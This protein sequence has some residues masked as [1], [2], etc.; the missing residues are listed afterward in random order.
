[1][2]RTAFAMFG[3]D[4][5]RQTGRPPIKCDGRRRSRDISWSVDDAWGLLVWRAALDPSDL[6]GAFPRIGR[7]V[8]A[9]V[10]AESLLLREAD[11]R[12]RR[13]ETRAA[14]LCGREGSLSVPPTLM[15]AHESEVARGFDEQQDVVRGS[16]DPERTLLAMVAPGASDHGALA[17]CV[18]KDRDRRLFAVLVARPGVRF[19]EEHA[20]HFGL[21]REP[22]AIACAHHARYTDLERLHAVDQADKQAL[23]SKLGSE[24]PI[25]G[26]EGG[27]RQVMTQVEQVARTDAPVLVMG[28]TGSGKEVIARAIHFRS[29]RAKGPVVRVNCGAIPPELIDSELFGHEKGSFTG[30]IAARQGWFE[31]ADGGTLFLDEIGEL[32]LAAQVRLL[33]VL[34][35]GTL[36]R[37]GGSKTLKVDVR[38][39]AATHRPLQEMVAEGT[40]REDLWYRISVFVLYL[41]ALRER[42]ADIPQLADHFAR[43]SASRLGVPPLHVTA[44]DVETLKAYGWPGNIRELGAVIERAAILGNGRRL[45]VGAALGQ[46]RPSGTMSVPPPPPESSDGPFPTLDEAMSKHI[47]AALARAG[48]IIEGSKGAAALLGINPH[49]LR[50]RMRKMGI[51]WDRFRKGARSAWARA[52][53]GV[54]P[55][56]VASPSAAWFRTASSRATKARSA[57]GPRTRSSHHSFESSAPAAS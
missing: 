53:L 51:D 46:S 23:M 7:L 12:V 11:L 57:S 9:R 14:S 40:F 49:T 28:E 31:R 45:D 15:T 2:S 32:S 17:A 41:P 18:A 30:A 26:A 29:K 4:G 20:Q 48:G 24:G 47:E 39:V 5:A 34:Q 36:E 6:G 27:L 16:T 10:P 21:V 19:T 44:A 25:I 54:G 37:V 50:A 38:L 56:P 1:M 52:P 55:P 43:R 33:R 35:D 22:L 42:L 3:R 8:A 13:V